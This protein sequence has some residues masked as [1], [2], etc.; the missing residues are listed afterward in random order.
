MWAD[1]TWIP[2][3]PIIF[4]KF[5]RQIFQLFGILCFLRIFDAE[6]DTVD[7]ERSFYGSKLRC[8]VS[9][10]WLQTW[11][12]KIMHKISACMNLVIGEW[13][14]LEQAIDLPPYQL[15]SENRC[16]NSGWVSEPKERVNSLDASRESWAKSRVSIPDES[17]NFTP[18]SLGI[19]C[20]LKRNYLGEQNMPI[21]SHFK[22]FRKI[23]QEKIIWALY[24]MKKI[25]M[26]PISLRTR[27]WKYT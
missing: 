25:K 20:L 27:E 13:E 9:A 26:N 17:F 19:S 16:V 7:F 14:C 3:I 8:N 12:I 18:G 22:R 2:T 23:K 10:M 24:M 11:A 1:A 21:I 15:Y 6:Y 4:Y 5:E